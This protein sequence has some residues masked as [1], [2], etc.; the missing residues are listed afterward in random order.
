MKGS[1]RK[2]AK[3]RPAAVHAP[4]P[5]QRLDRVVARCRRQ[6]DHQADRAAHKTPRAGTTAPGRHASTTASTTEGTLRRPRTRGSAWPRIVA[7]TRRDDKR[8]RRTNERCRVPRAHEEVDQVGHQDDESVEQGRREPPDAQARDGLPLRPALIVHAAR[9]TTA[10]APQR[11][12]F[13]RERLSQ[14]GVALCRR[15]RFRH[16]PFSPPG[17]RLHCCLRDHCRVISQARTWLRA[18]AA[19]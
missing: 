6:R 2:A 7:R 19:A 8:A 5:R 14:S 12:E 18:Y 15:A 16:L 10:V 13:G 1:I 9:C 4:V 17:S 3:V 11:V